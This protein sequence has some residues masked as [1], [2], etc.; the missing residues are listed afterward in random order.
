MQNQIKLNN[1][2]INIFS[3]TPESKNQ[4]I[5]FIFIIIVIFT[6]TNFIKLFYI[7]K[8]L[9]FLIIIGI[10]IKGHV[11]MINNQIS[12]ILDELEVLSLNIDISNDLTKKEKNEQA[13]SITNNIIEIK[14]ESTCF[15]KTI[16]ADLK[17]WFKY[18][19]IVTEERNHQYDKI[20]FNK[21]KTKLDYLTSLDEKID[22]LKYMIMLLKKF[23]REE[24]LLIYINLKRKYEIKYAYTKSGSFLQIIYVTFS[25]NVLTLLTT[26]FISIL[27]FSFVW[28]ISQEDY[29]F[30]SIKLID[31]NNNLFIT[32]IYNFLCI[33]FNLSVFHSL[34]NQLEI[35]YFIFVKLY[36]FVLITYYLIKDLS[37]KLGQ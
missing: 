7:N 13:L 6:L 22:I 12:T 30:F 15:R 9:I 3:L 29:S 25:Y 21:I 14:K 1:Y 20:D 5:P 19:L 33:T 8:S 10:I 11:F 18:Y 31:F 37:M 27:F 16:Y 35:I 24:E 34:D 26:I 4:K 2:Y 23:N 28:Q 17:K 32:Y 36:F